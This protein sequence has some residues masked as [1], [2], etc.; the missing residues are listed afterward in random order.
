MYDKDVV[1][2][3]VRQFINASNLALIPVTVGHIQDEITAN[4][5]VTISRFT[6]P[7][8]CKISMDGAS[9]HKR[10][11]YPAPTTR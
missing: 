6:S 2:P 8:S 5:N 7:K 10:N 4:C 1:A 11:L 9:Y 3:V